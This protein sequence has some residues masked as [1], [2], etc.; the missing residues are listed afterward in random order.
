[1]FTFLKNCLYLLMRYK[2]TKEELEN[3][4]MKSMSNAGVC[5]ELGILASGGNYKTIKAKLK[6]LDIDTSHFTGAAWNQGVQFKPFMVKYDLV[7]VLIENSPYKSSYHL[8]DRLYREGLKEKKCEEC[9]LVDW[10]GK[11][12]TLEL[13]H[14][15]GNHSDNRLSNLRILCPNCHSQTKTFGN[16]KRE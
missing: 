10:N 4:V 9:G 14:I 16:K 5:R 7:D 2:H 11:P 13:D 6:E 8:K 1:V 12:I 3:A 15:N